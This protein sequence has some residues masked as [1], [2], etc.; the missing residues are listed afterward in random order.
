M[1]AVEQF[2]KGNIFEVLTV[3]LWFAV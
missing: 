3:H 1:Y 2:L